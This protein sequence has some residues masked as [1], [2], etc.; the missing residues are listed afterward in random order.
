ML[1][2]EFNISPG[3]NP[4]RRCGIWPKGVP[5]TP[6]GNLIALDE[7]HGFA[8]W[9]SCEDFSTGPV[10]TDEKTQK[11]ND[12]KVR[13]ML[14]MALLNEHLLTFNQ[15]KDA[16]ILFAAIQTTF[17]GNDATKKTQK[18]LLKQII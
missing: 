11:K 12:V 17:G 1:S 6:L 4:P 5:I 2:Y 3:H 18:T 15:Y 8:L 7:A 14:L 16:K 9:P 13:N 10:T